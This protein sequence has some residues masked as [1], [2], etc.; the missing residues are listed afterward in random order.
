MSVLPDSAQ[1]AGGR[2]FL[3]GVGA[4]E[5]AEEYGTPL[6]VYCTETLRARTDAYLRGLE[7]YPGPSRAVYACKAN[8]TVGVLR[9]IFAQGFGA[10]AASEGELAAALRAGVDPASVVVH[11][12]N[13]SEQ[14][15]RAAIEAHAGLIVVDHAGELETIE[16]LAAQAGRVQRALVRVT[17]GI[18]PDTHAKIVTGHASSKFGLAPVDALDALEAA[19]SLLHVQPCGLHVHLGSQIRDTSPYVDAIDR[20]AEF[21]EEHGLGDLPVLDIG[22]GFAIAYTEREAELAVEPALEEICA[23]LAE[24]LIA[25]GLEMPELIVEPGRSVVGP[26][27]VTLYRVG[28]VKETGGGVTYAAVDGGMSDNPRPSLYSAEYEAI[29]CDRADAVGTRVYAI[30]GKHCESGDVLI[31]RARLPELRAGDLLA[32]PATGAYAASMASNYNLLPRPAAVLVE[33]GLPQLI[34]RRETLAELLGREL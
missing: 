8:A 13:P 12:N 25:H 6:Y 29:V 2:L 17:P 22:G 21:V 7:W 10:D 4:E 30:A 31:E 11:G 27:G 5:L 26:A 28:A 20:L 9:A 34:Q 19:S 23:H 15:L 18:E 24:R 1:T 33:D 32:V 3:G 16:R 14:D